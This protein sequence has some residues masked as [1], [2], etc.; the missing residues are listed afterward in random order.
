MT[1]HVRAEQMRI[2]TSI[3]H[4]A[5]GDE[6]MLFGRNSIRNIQQRVSREGQEENDFAE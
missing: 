1:N 5:L 3:V 6:Q 4:I 2:S